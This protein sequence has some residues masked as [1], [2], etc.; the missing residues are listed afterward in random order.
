MRTLVLAA[1]VIGRTAAREVLGAI[2]L[3]AYTFDKVLAYHDILVKFDKYIPY[4]PKED[5]FRELAKQVGEMSTD[6]LVGWVGVQDYGA[7]HSMCVTGAGVAF[8]HTRSVSSR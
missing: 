1:L 6:L 5:A 2:H 4:G 7:S 8:T 3:D